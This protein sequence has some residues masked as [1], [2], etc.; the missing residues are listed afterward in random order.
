MH[1]STVSLHCW[2]IPHEAT[3]E[4]FSEYSTSDSRVD[5]RIIELRAHELLSRHHHF[6]GRAGNFEYEFQEHVLIVRG[7][8]PTF[9]LKQLLQTVL[10]DVD[11][12]SWIDNQVDVV[13]S[14][15]MSSV[16]QSASL[17]SD[18]TW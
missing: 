3:V 16:R 2:S 9:Y 1:T 18:Q 12:V 4:D 17:P 5:V 13:S 10:K 15:G 8:V 6:R 14:Y 11:G 7:R